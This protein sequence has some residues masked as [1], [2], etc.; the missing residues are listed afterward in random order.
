MYFFAN[1][2]KTIVLFCYSR[3]QYRYSQYIEHNNYE[4]TAKIVIQMHIVLYFRNCLNNVRLHY[5]FN[6]FVTNLPKKFYS[7][8]FCQNFVV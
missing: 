3:T 8:F 4:T 7:N 5:E 2:R 1:D 6:I